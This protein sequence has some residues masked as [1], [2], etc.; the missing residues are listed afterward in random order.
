MNYIW[1]SDEIVVFDELVP[2]DRIHAGRNVRSDIGDIS[3]LIDSISQVGIINP[4]VVSE[5]SDGYVLIAGERRF[6][7][8]QQLGFEM[9]PCKIFYELSDSQ[10]YEIMLAENFNRESMNA[11]DEAHAFRMMIDKYGYTQEKLAGIVGHSQ[12][13]IAK[14]LSLLELPKEVQDLVVKEIISPAHALQFLSFRDSFV[15]GAISDYFSK[16]IPKDIKPV[17]QF[18]DQLASLSYSAAKDAGIDPC[19]VATY[20]IGPDAYSERCSKCENH[21]GSYCYN[22]S[23]HAVL[24]DE[25]SKQKKA[26]KEKYFE[27]PQ[28]DPSVSS[29]RIRSDIEHK[30]RQYLGSVCAE[31]RDD[32]PKVLADS[33]LSIQEIFERFSGSMIPS[34][35]DNHFSLEDIL[36]YNVQ[37]YFFDYFHEGSSLEDFVRAIC[38]ALIRERFDYDID[39]DDDDDVVTV[40]TKILRDHGLSSSV[41]DKKKSKAIQSDLV[42]FD[43]KIEDI[44]RNGPSGTVDYSDLPV[45]QEAS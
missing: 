40:Y 16:N 23:C 15:Y 26:E 30:R 7:A 38:I 4:L 45:P 31:I 11:I 6:R 3:G 39:F 29:H 28:Q 12:S 42:L 24:V 32:I 9:V 18:R 36:E 43:K 20:D 14:H 1:G 2:L 13:Y 27:D 37:D 25:Y 41:F 17:A 22:P 33:G 35:D 44:D 19:Y 5:T 8:A 21:V 34:E 10:I